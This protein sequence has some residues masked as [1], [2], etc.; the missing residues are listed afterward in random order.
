MQFTIRVELEKCGTFWMTQFDFRNSK[1][2]FY[3]NTTN[4]IAPSIVFILLLS[5]GAQGFSLEYNETDHSAIK[6]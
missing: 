5:I 2:L 1:T 3:H 4:F 6:V